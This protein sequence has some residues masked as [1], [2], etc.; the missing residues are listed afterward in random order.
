MARVDLAALKEEILVFLRNQNFLTVGVRGVTT[1]SDNFTAGVGQT[2]FNLS[3]TTVKNVRSVTLNASP[4]AFGTQY[5]VNYQTGV[6]T[7]PSASS[8]NAIVVQYDYGSTDK[9]YSDFPQPLLTRSDFPRIGFDYGPSVVQEFDLGANTNKI[10]WTMQVAYYDT[11]IRNVDT[12]T[13]SLRNI[14]L[15]NKKNWYNTDFITCN[16]FTPMLISPFGKDKIFTRSILLT[17]GPTIE[18]P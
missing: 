14:F 15:N 8:G 16:G 2:T 13:E 10:E 5:S 17:I 3:Q 7:I 11:S 4:L 12:V 9:I 1:T 18:V 6:V